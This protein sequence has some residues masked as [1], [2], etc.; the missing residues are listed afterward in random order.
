MADL[1]DD[2]ETIASEIVANAINAATEPRGTLPAIILGIHHSPGQA[3]HHRLGQRPRP[4]PAPPTPTPTTRRGR[5]LG[6]VNALTAN[7]WGWWPTPHSGGKVVSRHS[8]RSARRRGRPLMLIPAPG[9][10]HGNLSRRTADT[11]RGR[12]PVQGST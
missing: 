6:I 12:P 5:G 9:P 2:A 3:P 4:P 11:R 8:Q 1:T 7:N 10:G